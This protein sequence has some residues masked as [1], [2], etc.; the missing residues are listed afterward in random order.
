[1]SKHTPGPWVI[2]REELDESF[3]DEE[4]EMAFPQSIGPIADWTPECDSSEGWRI[5]ADARLISAAPDMLAALECVTAWADMPGDQGVDILRRH[6]FDGDEVRADA[7]V[8]GRVR[9]AT[10]KARGES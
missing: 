7:F 2:V 8:I 6:G 10:A 1:M 5:E 9:A 3:S 4:Q